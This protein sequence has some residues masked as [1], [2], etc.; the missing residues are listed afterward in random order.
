MKTVRVSNASKGSILGERVDI[1]DTSLGRM[2]GLLGRR[3]LDAGTGL[4]IFPSQAVHTLGMRFAIDLVF[5]DKNWRVVGAQ[6]SLAPYRISRMHW[7]ARCV[8]EL[9][10]GTIARTSTAIGD[11]LVLE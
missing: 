8:L 10:V 7:R 3:S 1:A 11:E 9:P 6:R 4:V 5:A 2:R